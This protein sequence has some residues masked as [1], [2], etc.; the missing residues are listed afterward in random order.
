[1]KLQIEIPKEF[2]KDFEDDKFT[3]Y[4]QRVYCAIPHCAMTGTYEEETTN[5]F[6]NSF[7]KAE[8]V[9]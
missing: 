8:V 4:F 9:R 5:M 2:E 3:D 7:K 6:L 1:M